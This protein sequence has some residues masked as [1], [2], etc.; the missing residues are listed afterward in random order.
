MVIF[1]GIT[2]KVVSLSGGKSYFKMKRYEVRF[3]KDGYYPAA[4]TINS[5]FNPWYIGNLCFGGLTGM[6]LVDPLT[7]AMYKIENDKVIAVLNPS[8]TYN[9]MPASLPITEPN[10]NQTTTPTSVLATDTIK[11]IEP[12]VQDSIPT[13]KVKPAEIDYY[14]APTKKDSLK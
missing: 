1:E 2:P 4:A 6:L 11:K 8:A 10:T 5:T 9:A 3:T 12:M 7:G 14:P 13:K